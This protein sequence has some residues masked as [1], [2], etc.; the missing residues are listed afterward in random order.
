VSLRNRLKRQLR[1]KQ[2]RH[3][4]ADEQLNLSIGT[5]IKAIREKQGMTQAALAEKIGTKQTGVSRIESANYSRWSIAV[6]RRLAEAF[7]LRLRVSFE[8][9]GTLWK[10]VDDF[11]RESLERR[12]FKEDPEF[13]ESANAA[14]PIA[15]VPSNGVLVDALLSHIATASAA[16]LRFPTEQRP[17]QSPDDY[18]LPRRRPVG[19][20]GA[21]LGLE[22]SA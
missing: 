9:F 3:A 1:D 20:A 17:Q 5:Q 7:D 6:L 22:V 15:A 13:R 16:D 19:A 14:P 10:E 12:E 11:S 4:Y 2:F 18:V 8:E 21:A